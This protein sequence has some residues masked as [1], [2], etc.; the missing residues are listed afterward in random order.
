MA[1]VMYSGKM[2]SD[3]IDAYLTNGV[4]D[5]DLKDGD[6][7][8]LGDLV[9]D[10][11]YVATGDVQYDVY[12]ADFPAAA[13]DEVV[14]IDY[15]GISEGEIND[16]E[17]KIGKKLYNLTVPAGT[18]FRVRRLALHDKFW[19]G[20]SNFVAAPTVGEFAIATAGKGEFTAAAA[21]PNDGLAVKVLVEKDLTTGMRSQGKIYLVEVVQ[22]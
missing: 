22:L 17:Y 2:V 20:E 4:A 21:L 13:T 19:L 5:T 14:I 6:L 15:A 7:V 18:N 12:E 9:A 16:N 8:A 10:T 1:K 11:T 3:Q